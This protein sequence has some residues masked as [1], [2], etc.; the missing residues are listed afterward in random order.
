MCLVWRR[1]NRCAMI[2]WNWSVARVRILDSLDCIGGETN[3]GWSPKFKR[4]SSMNIAKKSFCQSI[5]L[6]KTN[7]SLDTNVEERIFSEVIRTSSICRH[8]LFDALLLSVCFS[9]WLDRSWHIDRVCCV[10]RFPPR[11]KSLVN[12]EHWHTFYDFIFWLT[13]RVD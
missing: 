7:T 13:Y 2:A 6:R 4:R 5:D 10:D 12:Q 8:R 9:R 11:E 3:D 1:F